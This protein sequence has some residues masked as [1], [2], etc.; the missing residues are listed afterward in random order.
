MLSAVRIADICGGGKEK[1]VPMAWAHVDMAKALWTVPA[2]KMHDKPHV[3]PLSDAAI[4]LLAAM[5]AR[6]DPESDFVFPGHKAGCVVD[7]TS[8]RKLVKD[9]GYSGIATVHGF[10]ATFRTW[11]SETT[12]YA[13]DVIEAALAHA[14]GELDQAY[15]RGSY[16]EKR[17]LLMQAW[18]KFLAAGNV[19]PLAAIA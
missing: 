13:K 18:A 17:R 15:H 7:D 19:V 9:M 8:V 5:R 6:R 2:T 3:V 14:Q 12:D 16:L 11:A 4:S 10:R 1:T